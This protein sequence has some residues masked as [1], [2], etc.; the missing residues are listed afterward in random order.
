[1]LCQCLSDRAGQV[2]AQPRRPSPNVDCADSPAALSFD[3]SDRILNLNVHA[4]CMPK[5]DATEIG[6]DHTTG[7]ALEQPHREFLLE[8]SDALRQGRLCDPEIRSC[9]RDTAASSD[10][11]K[12]L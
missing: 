6:E 11:K 12:V 1:M 10:E 8:Q 9:S 2:T 3:L 4:L 7:M 5:Q